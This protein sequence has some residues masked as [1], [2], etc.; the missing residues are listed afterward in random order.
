MGWLWRRNELQKRVRAEHQPQQPQ[1][2]AR[3]EQQP[4]AG[5]DRD[6]T[7]HDPEL[8]R[9]LG[10]LKA[11]MARFGQVALVLEP[12]RLRHQVILGRLVLVRDRLFQTSRLLVG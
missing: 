7:E 2:A 8:E 3:H 1:T 10:R 4:G 12:E 11:A 9:R 6:R 5:Y